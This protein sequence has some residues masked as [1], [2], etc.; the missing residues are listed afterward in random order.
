M[1]SEA[2]STLESDL[3]AL[4]CIIFKMATGKPAFPGNG[5]F[6]VKP[7]ILAAQV[8]WDEAEGMDEQCVD[9]IRKLLVKKPKYR[10][11]AKN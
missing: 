8:D 5:I 10:L 3:W 11:G 2:T 9:L 7:A 1:V 4:G 6:Q